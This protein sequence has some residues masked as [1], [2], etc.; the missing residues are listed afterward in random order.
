MRLRVLEAVSV[1]V[2]RRYRAPA[3]GGVLAEPPFPEIASQLQANRRILNN[4][5]IRID[6]T[7]LSDFRKEAIADVLAAAREYHRDAGEPVPDFPNGPLMMSG[8]QPELTHVGV[9]VK[10]FALHGLARKHGLTPLNLI[11]DNDTAKTTAT[12]VP[13]LKPTQSTP[14]P[15][16]PRGGEGGKTGDGLLP[17]PLRG[18]DGGGVSSLDPSGIHLLS[19][20]YDRFEGEVPF[21]T[22]P[23]VDPK[24]FESFP[25]RVMPITRSWGFQPILPEF[26]DEMRRQR[27]RTPILGEIV[28]GTR[29]FWERRWGCQNLEIPLGRMCATNAFQRFARH[30]IS[31][32]PRFHAI[33]NEC[34][35]EYRRRYY[36]RSRNHPVPDLHRDGNALEAPFWTVRKGDARRSRLMVRSG[37]MP[38]GP[39]LRSRALTT[40][41]FLRVCLSDGFI[42]G[43]GG[44]KYDEVTDAI[45]G[46]W[47]GI[48]APGF[49]VITA[50]LRLPLPRFPTTP[51]DLHAAERR[52][53]DLE[54]NPQRYLEDVRDANVRR[55]LEEKVRL[56][57]AEPAGKAERKG[58]FR[59]LSE[60]TQRLR[61]F[62]ADQLATATKDLER[63]SVEA[64]ANELL[65]RRDYAW[66][67]FPE[68]VVSTFCRKLL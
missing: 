58:W 11:V 5:S 38:L 47:L 3:E 33:Y 30:I 15:S 60:Q 32:L 62:V 46:R 8:H 26:W 68:E 65:M 45:L 13:V 29:R 67:M 19:I 59:R 34:V 36:I 53:R 66:C 50:T 43:I 10:T 48:E 57:T 63:R 22:R 23:I 52:L 1:S 40:T 54:W 17:S 20:P 39:Q 37:E 28:A 16:P 42:H 61:P 9:L 25:D 24:L 56:I 14:P 35:A 49:I 21:E 7:P 4:D 41:M 12:R 18:G 27:K 55:L 2:T 51:A 64:S 44:A 31:D 6:G